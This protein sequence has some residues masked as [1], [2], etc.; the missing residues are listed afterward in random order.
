MYDQFKGSIVQTNLLILIARK[1]THLNNSN[2]T[3]SELDI[4]VKGGDHDHSKLSN[5][6]IKITDDIAAYRLKFDKA[7]NRREF[8]MRL[9]SAKRMFE[10][11]LSE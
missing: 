5:E 4:S 7:I 10:Q 11:K 9:L 8:G 1:E 3:T 2:P 6:A